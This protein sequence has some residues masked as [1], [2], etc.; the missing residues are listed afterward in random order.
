MSEPCEQI[1]RIATL[2][3]Q[4]EAV[5]DTLTRIEVKVEGI[6]L[7][8]SKVAVLETNHGH[9]TET[10]ARAFLRIEQ[11]EKKAGEHDRYL[12]FTTGF[13]AAVSVFWTV[14]GYRINAEVDEVIKA[15]TEMRA[16]IATDK[17]TS[18]EDLRKME[19]TP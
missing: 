12:W 9:H 3:N 15:V 7:S 11:I 2:E 5:K 6:A 19:K 8:L 10:I 13:V 14:I 1:G 4:Y 18:P 16:H 17:L